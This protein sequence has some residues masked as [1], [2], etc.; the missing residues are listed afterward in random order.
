MIKV[1]VAAVAACSILA[2]PAQAACWNADEASAATVRELQSMMMVAALRCQAAGRGIMDEYN[3][4]V[5]A[6]RKTISAMNDRIKGHFI[7]AMGPVGGQRGYDSYTTSMANAYGAGASGSE[8][9]GS[10]ASL[11][12]EATMMAGSLDGLLLLADRQGLVAKL[13]EGLC[14]DAAP[15]AVASADPAMGTVR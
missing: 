8:T 11:A 12:R 1:I 3:G 15:L 5:V 13:P 7:R 10:V 14:R 4:F 9:C 6:N 2:M